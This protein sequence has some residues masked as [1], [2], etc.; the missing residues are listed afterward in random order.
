M[1][2]EHP[3]LPNL[4]K[5]KYDAGDQSV[6]SYFDHGIDWE[7]DPPSYLIVIENEPKGLK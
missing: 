6:T 3:T 4:K 2:R 1:K 5:N 7:P